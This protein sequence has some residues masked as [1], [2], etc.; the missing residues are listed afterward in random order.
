MGACLSQ[1][2]SFDQISGNA[3]LLT[4][5]GSETSATSLCGTTYLLLT[6]PET[7][8]KLNSEV[9]G[10]FDRVDAI[11]VNAVTQLPYLNAVINESLRMYPPA[12][13]DLVRIVPPEGKQVAGHYVAGGV[14][15]SARHDAGSD[16]EN[17]VTDNS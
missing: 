4:L 14:R 12:A 8:E 13:A 2:L 9:R 5:A 3:F 1:N 7:L 11:T 15:I 16:S 6:H 10:A 17:A